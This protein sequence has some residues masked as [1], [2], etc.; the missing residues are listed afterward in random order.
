MKVINLER[1]RDARRKAV[2]ERLD[3]VI[4][5][6]RAMPI[7]ERA[8]VL[9]SCFSVVVGEFARMVL[10]HT[11]PSPGAKSYARRVVKKSDEIRKI[12]RRRD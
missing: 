2:H 9:V 4:E 1:E 8:D 12:A 11:D 5:T 10:D 3:K 7:N 6:L